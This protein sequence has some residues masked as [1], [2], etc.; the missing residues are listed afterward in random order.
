MVAN[1]GPNPSTAHG[2]YNATPPTEVDQQAGPIQLDANGNLLVALSGSGGPFGN[3]N[4][5]PV[6]FDAE[7]AATTAG[8]AGSTSVLIGGFFD[9][10]WPP[11]LTSLQQRGLATDVNGRPFT[12]SRVEHPTA[13]DFTAARINQS[14][15]TPQ[16]LVAGVSLQS[17]RV[18]RIHLYAVAA[19]VATLTDGSGGTIF[20]D[21]PFGAGGSIVF[22][23]SSDYLYKTTAG[24][25]FFL[26][27]PSAVQMYGRLWYTQAV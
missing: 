12:R 24:N 27:T 14:S 10:A 3:G 5:L 20:E 25:G 13:T 9:N 19:V 4:G 26:S 6:V 7:G 23:D 21:F 17:V 15:A 11:T 2:V 18:Y 8:T 1:S 16:A 22:D